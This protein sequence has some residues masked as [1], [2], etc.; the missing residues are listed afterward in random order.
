MY[1]RGSAAAVVVYDISSE[2][3]LPGSGW[4][5]RQIILHCGLACQWVVDL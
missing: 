2:V 3:G 5:D 1:Y 4:A